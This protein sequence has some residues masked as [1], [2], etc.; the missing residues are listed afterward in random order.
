M[1]RVEVRECNMMD[2][3]RY[4]RYR[5]EAMEWLR[6]QAGFDVQVDDAEQMESIDDHI[7]NV[8]T[9]AL[10][11]RAECLAAT[12][13]WQEKN[14]SGE[15]E[16]IARPDEWTSVEGFATNVPQVFALAL[17]RAAHELNPGL[18]VAEFGEPEK[19]SGSVNV[20]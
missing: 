14:G 11:Y 4:T 19:K 2:L 17:T 10:N 1:R 15:W 5:R 8:F 3:T 13:K 12:G 18:W 20:S 6:E 9:I 16:D 7:V